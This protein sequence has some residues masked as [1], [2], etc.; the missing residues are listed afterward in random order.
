MLK[1]G[2]IPEMRASQTWLQREDSQLGRFL[3]DDRTQPSLKDLQTSPLVLSSQSLNCVINRAANFHIK[4]G[5]CPK[6]L[7]VG[8]GSHI[9]CAQT[10][11]DRMCE[12]IVN[13]VYGRPS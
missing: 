6:G 13:S 10:L 1:Q 12:K 2:L 7:N 8:M 4:S 11:Q 9:F 3:E 5:K